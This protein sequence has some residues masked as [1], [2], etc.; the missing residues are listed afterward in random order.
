MAEKKVTFSI[1]ATSGRI[2]QK[3]SIFTGGTLE[4]VIDGYTGVAPVI[5]LFHRRAG[6]L[7][8]V[9]LTELAEGGTRFLDLNTVAVRE[10]FTWNN[11]N[12]P[13][14]TVVCDAYLVDGSHSEIVDL[15]EA[16][17]L[18]VGNPNVIA[19]GQV[20]IG[21]SPITFESDGRAVTM[22]GPKGDPGPRGEQGEKGERGEQGPRGEKGEQGQ[23]GEQGPRGEQGFQGPRGEKGEQGEQG[24]Q[25]EKGERGDPGAQGAQGQPGNN[26]SP[27]P[28]GPVGPKG[29]RGEQ[30]PQGPQGE[31]GERG[32]QGP[33][34]Y[35]GDKGETGEQGPKGNQGDIGPRGFSAYEIAVQHGYA[36]TEEQW[37][38]EETGLHYALDVIHKAITEQGEALDV[39]IQSLNAMEEV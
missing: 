30:G 36:G 13:G 1:D 4:A 26:G 15:E 17:A 8:P 16:A 27:G 6:E 12:R 34:G 9:A 35:R 31:K 20:T 22:K 19:Q 23:Q 7:K 39:I 25:G 18:V 33:R 32:E 11:K 5:V 37:N 38:A 24:P 28:T 2:F 29:E 21:W 3:G 14:A 10:C